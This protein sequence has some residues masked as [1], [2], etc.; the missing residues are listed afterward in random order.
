MASRRTDKFYGFVSSLGGA[1]LGFFEFIGGISILFRDA[2]RAVL[3]GVR[4][5]GPILGR[6]FWTQ[7]VRAG[8]RALPVVFLV[9]FF[10]GVILALIGGKILSTLGFTQYIGDLLGVGIVLELGPLLS[11]IIMTGYI[12]AALTAEIATMV[13]S[14][15]ITALRTM[16]LHPIRFIVVPRLLAVMLMVPAV[17]FLGDAVGIFGGALVSE[18]VLDVS[19][20]AF[21][22]RAWASL[23]VEDVWRGLLK[24]TVFGLVIG[25]IGCYQ[26]F[27][28]KGG[29]EGV[30]RSTTNSVV[31]SIIA[32][33][34]IDAILNY[35]LLFRF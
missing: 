13:V 28:V 25:T 17:T 35:L 20:N 2:M 22:E 34:V 32:I 6:A 24:A 14:E 5:R 29:A 1:T 9:N 30:G 19:G 21:Y 33:I 7:A 26:G 16:S 4:G 15:E 8:P 18:Q 10:V 31:T 27:S 11:G 12:G 23:G 3:R